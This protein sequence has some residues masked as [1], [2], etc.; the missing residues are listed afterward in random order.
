MNLDRLKALIRLA[1]NNPSE[2]EA[3]L[4]ARKVCKILAENSF[5]LLNPQPQTAAGKMNEAR[6]W[7]DVKRSEEPAWSSKP[8]A[9]PGFDASEFFRNWKRPEWNGF[10]PSEAQKRYWTDSAPYVDAPEPDLND[11]VGRKVN[12]NMNP[13]KKKERVQAMRKCTKC[14]FEVMTFRI[15]EVPWICNPCHWKDV[16][17]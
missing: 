9:G 5:A 16:G 10:R 4:A 8:P 7:N 1:N 14:G 12:I 15:D 11:W 17:L 3:N 2:H 6:T 13:D